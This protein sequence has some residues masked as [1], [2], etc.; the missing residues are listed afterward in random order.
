[1]AAGHEETCRA[2]PYF[3]PDVEAA[4]TPGGDAVGRNY[5]K[6]GKARADS[7]RRGRTIERKTSGSAQTM[8]I[9]TIRQLLNVP[10]T[11]L[12]AKTTRS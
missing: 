1:M 12:R 8:R 10:V 4:S 3:P 7:T 2:R 6:D 11:V 5:T 9:R